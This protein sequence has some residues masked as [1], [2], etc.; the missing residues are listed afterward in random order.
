MTKKTITDWAKKNFLH[1]FVET[2]PFPSPGVRDFLYQLAAAEELLSKVH[3]V[4]NGSFLRPLLVVS[5]DGSGMPPLLFISAD[6]QSSAD[7]QSILQLLEASTEEA[8]YLTLYFPDRS[9]S[10]TYQAVM[11]ECPTPFDSAYADQVMFQFELKLLNSGIKRDIAKQELMQ[12]ID[13]ALDHKDQR[14]F[15]RLVKKLKSL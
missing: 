8:I 3:I 5:T 13:A 1:W 9:T 7:Y 12:Q 6:D 11:E 15:A 14:K 2:Y 4:M 10:E